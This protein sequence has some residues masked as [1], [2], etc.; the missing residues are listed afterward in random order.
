[1]T[2]AIGLTAGPIMAGIIIQYFDYVM[3]LLIFAFI[4]LVVGAFTVSF[5]PKSLDKTS[6]CVTVEEKSKK[7][8]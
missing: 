8:S 5:L 2:G 3:T 7:G 6:K 1:M 4:M